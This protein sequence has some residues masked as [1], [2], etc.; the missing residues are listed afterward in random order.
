M[1]VLPDFGP[2]PSQGPAGVWEAWVGGSV[3]GWVGLAR[4]N[5]AVD[6]HHRNFIKDFNLFPLNV[7]AVKL[8]S[9]QK[10]IVTRN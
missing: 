9:G 6:S 8:N 10:K 2:E 3:G 4:L 5:L 7:R 1:G